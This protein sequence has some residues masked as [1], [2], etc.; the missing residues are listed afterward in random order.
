MKRNKARAKRA[1]KRVL[2]REG[3]RLEWGYKMVP[4]KGRG[5]KH[6]KKSRGRGR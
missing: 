4:V 1:I 2:G 6:G 5:V 3:L